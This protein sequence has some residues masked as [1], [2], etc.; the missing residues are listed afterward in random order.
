MTAISR[1]TGAPAP[2][3]HAH[4]SISGSAY[5]NPIRLANERTNLRHRNPNEVLY[6]SLLQHLHHLL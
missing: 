4:V 2:L 6:L 3:G 1:R 5:L